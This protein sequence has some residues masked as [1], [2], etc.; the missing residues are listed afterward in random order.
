MLT[1]VSAVPTNADERPRAV[2][3]DHDNVVVD[4]APG[5]RVI[6]NLIDDPEDYLREWAASLTALA[7]RLAS[8]SPADAGFE[9]DGLKP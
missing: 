6:L 3:E 2:L 4:V 1:N 8:E 7:D 9:L 5:W